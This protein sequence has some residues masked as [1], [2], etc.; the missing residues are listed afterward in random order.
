MK[1]CPIHIWYA[2]SLRP[3]G[4]HKR[5]VLR[6][7]AAAGFL[8]CLGAVGFA[9]GQNLF[10]AQQSVVNALPAPYPLQTRPPYT[11]AL[12][13]GHG[14]MDLGA[15]ALVNEVEVCEKTTDDLYALLD[16]DPNYRPVRTREN[17]EDRSTSDRAQ[18]ATDNRASLL[19]SIHANCDRS[20]RQSHGFECFPTPP[21]R[22]YSE[23][24][25]RFAQCIVVKMK[26]AGH[27]LHG[28]T[29]IRFAYYSG[30]SKRI[31]PSSDT[32][33]RS[34]KSFGMVE[35]PACPA[36]LAEQCFL[37]NYKDVENWASEAGCQKAA[38]VYYRA[39]CAYFGTAPMPLT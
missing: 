26:A 11:V 5:N 18:T 36:V 37:T 25:M 31:V 35:K 2:F 30:K 3:A 13:P 9:C 14:G 8:L 12:D 24:S 20:T 6:L 4:Q 16:A 7:A 28:E 39:I 21:G 10:A 17:G 38:T 32:R 29:G 15:E 33:V 34:Q 19:L 22:R 27:R 23:E 1:F